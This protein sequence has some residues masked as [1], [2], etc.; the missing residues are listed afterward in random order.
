MT[1]NKNNN[2]NDEIKILKQTNDF[3]GKKLLSRV[4]KFHKKISEDDSENLD[5]YIKTIFA[6]H[7]DLLPINKRIQELKK[8]V[9]NIYNNWS[10][11]KNADM[12]KKNE[13]AAPA[14]DL[15]KK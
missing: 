9:E 11:V 10:V 14:D 1:A 2:N 13:Q 15:K 6:E 4:A 3:S 5:D 12:R 8:E 7:A